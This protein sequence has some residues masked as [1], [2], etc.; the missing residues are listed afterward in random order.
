MSDLPADSSTD[1]KHASDAKAPSKLPTIA[2]ASDHAG[3]EQKTELFAWLTNQGYQVLDFGPDNDDRVDYP[4]YAY[5]VAQAVSSSQV[6]IGILLCGTGI[7]MSI[8][9]NKVIG[10]RAANL[11]SV[12]F[13]QLAREHNA[14][15]VAT[16][17][18]RFVDVLQNQ[19]ILTAFLNSQ[20]LADRHAQ[21]VRKIKELEARQLTGLG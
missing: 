17:S 18:A 1:V 6:D 11:T 19:Q 14:A 4:D 16:L 15:N 13:A 9:A 20:P 10:V 5:L 8:A 21:R 7:G 3:Y 12:Q 2:I